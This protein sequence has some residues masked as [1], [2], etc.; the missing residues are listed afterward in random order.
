MISDPQVIFWI[1]L[2]YIVAGTVKGVVGSG[3]PTIALGV[4][5]TVIGLHAA[6]ALMLVPTIVTNLWQALTG[7]HL[8]KVTVRIWPFLLVVLVTIWIGAEALT[9]VNV[10]W[11]S[12]LL[13]LLL[14]LYGMLGLLR[15]PLSIP[16]KK[17]T[18]VGLVAG[19]FSGLLGGMTGS[20]G[21]PG[22]PYLQAIGF[23]RDQLIQALGL[24]FAV[25]SIS[26]AVALGG[27][28]LLSLDLGIASVLA[29]VPA[30]IGMALGQTLRYRLS[31]TLFRKLFFVSQILLGGYIVYRALF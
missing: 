20:F 31:E 10:A 8:R 21:I 24:L 5:T 29:M 1:A 2:T 22:I 17:V 18:R 25:S 26:L 30:L 27:H 7:G 19:F 9:R 14:A 16:E 13:G 3:L 28:R 15:P 6:M 12:A 4:L 11:L 23:P